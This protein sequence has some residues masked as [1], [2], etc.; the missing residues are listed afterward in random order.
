MRCASSD[1]RAHA[2]GTDSPESDGLRLLRTH[3]RSFA[4]AAA[5]LDRERRIDLACLYAFFRSVDDLVDGPNPDPA[6]TLRLLGDLRAAVQS[7]DASHPLLRFVHARQ[8]LRVLSPEP[9]LRFI[10]AISGDLDP[11]RAFTWPELRRYAEGVAGTV[12]EAALAVLGAN[13]AGA[14][15]PARELGVAMQL[16]N[17]ARDVLEDAA[18]GRVYLPRECGSVEPGALL[19]G[20]PDARC[21]AWRAI[22]E[23]LARAEHGYGIASS[24]IDALPER[25]RRTV[26]VAAFVYR[27]IGRCILRR[28][29]RRYWRGRTVVSGPRRLLAAGTALWRCTLAGGRVA[30]TGAPGRPL[31]GV[32]G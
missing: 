13:A 20:D 2:I 10:D 27:E 21:G 3:G 9:L 5:F 12:G 30:R 29:E 8:R 16:T 28:G 11:G 19:A 31:S 24:A 17:V 23:V 7:G 26:A 6:H 15:A 32:G 18:R 4:L 22:T 25:A 14:S 1:P